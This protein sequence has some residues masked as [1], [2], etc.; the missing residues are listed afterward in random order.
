MPHMVIMGQT[1]RVAQCSGAVRALGFSTY[2]PRYREQTVVRGK[3]LWQEHLLLGNYFF[4]RW[5]DDL[6]LVWDRIFGIRSCV[7]MI[8]SAIPVDWPPA[9]KYAPQPAMVR[10]HEVDRI[11]S[12]ERNGF[13][14]L[15][16]HLTSDLTVGQRVK[17][18]TGVFAGMVGI[19]DGARGNLDSARI[20]MF[21]TNARVEFAPGVLAAGTT[22]R[23]QTKQ[24]A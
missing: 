3:K 24:F 1:G 11:K 2:V 14:S 21:G 4:A 7:G 10:D 17:V 19:Y 5:Q 15:D 23:A 6:E 20:E 9:V 8:L 13:V 16:A 12:R 22:E 18:L